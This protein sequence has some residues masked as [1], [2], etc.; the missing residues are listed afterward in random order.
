[1][2][3]RLL[4]LKHWFLSLKKLV[5]SNVL[6]TL[7]KSALAVCSFEQFCVEKI[8]IISFTIR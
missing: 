5:L 1:M 6:D 4:S 3:R 2:N 7:G 8:Q